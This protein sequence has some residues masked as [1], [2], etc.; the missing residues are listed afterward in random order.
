[1]ISLRR[2]R[3]WL[4]VAFGPKVGIRDWIAILK[5]MISMFRSPT[6]R[7]EWVRRTRI[8]YGCPLFDKER[9]TCRPFPDSDLGCGCYVPYSNLIKERCWGRERFGDN[10]GW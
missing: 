9:K 7:S 4:R 10:F 5:G 3:E 2:F 8:C 6:S 1:M